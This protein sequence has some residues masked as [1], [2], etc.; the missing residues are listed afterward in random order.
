M[1]LNVYEVNTL[2]SNFFYLIPAFIFLIKKYYFHAILHFFVFFASTFYHFC[3]DIQYIPEPWIFYNFMKCFESPINITVW[4]MVADYIFANVTSLSVLLLLI[5]PKSNEVVSMQ[6]IFLFANGLIILLIGQFLNIW[7][8]VVS[9][10]DLPFKYTYYFNITTACTF[11]FVLIWYIFGF[12]NGSMK[13]IFDECNEDYKQRFNI[14]LL[15][16]SLGLSFLGLFVWIALQ[17]ILPI[18]YH[19]IIHSVWH[20][21]TSTGSMLFAISI[22]V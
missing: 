4:L 15:M 9:D 2:A 3:F 5:P 17:N 13:N 22:K 6:P 16:I 8:S 21:L 18:Q 10:M 1:E 14:K 20:Y 12:T 11:L 19:S 7:G